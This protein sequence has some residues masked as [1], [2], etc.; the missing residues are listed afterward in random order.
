FLPRSNSG[1]VIVQSLIGERGG[2]LLYFEIGSLAPPVT[3]LTL[4]DIG[5]RLGELGFL[6]L[7][8]HPRWGLPGLH[9]NDYVYLLYTQHDLSSA[10][11]TP[12]CYRY[13][14]ERLHIS[15]AVDPPFIDQRTLIY[16]GPTYDA[17]TQCC[18]WAGDLHFVGLDTMVY[19]TGDHWTMLDKVQ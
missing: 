7:C 3:L 8:V 12:N 17:G 19:S 9:P 2:R 1:S 5:T 13:R 6:G 10:C 11:G 18:H 14:I 4:T 15:F 16:A